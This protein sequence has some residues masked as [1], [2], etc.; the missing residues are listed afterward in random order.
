MPKKYEQEFKD[1]AV[2][3]VR[4]QLPHY[5][6]RTEACIAVGRQEGVARETLRKWL[7]QAEVDSG[8][9]AGCH[10]RTGRRGGPVASGEQEAGRAGSDPLGGGDFLR[11]ST[12]L[13][14][15]M[16]VGF[17]DT[18]RCH[19][20]AV[21]S[22]CAVLTSQG[23]QVAARSYRRWH[24]RTTTAPAA[25]VCQRAWDEAALMNAIHSI[26]YR[27]DEVSGTYRLAPEGLY[28]RR[29]MQ[30]ALARTG[31][32]ASYGRVHSA[33]AALCLNGVRRGKPVRTTIANKD[34]VRA[35]D[36]L[37]RDFTAD[38]PDTTWVADFTYVRTWAGF[39][40][41]A[42]ILDC[43]SQRIVAWHAATS[44]ATALVM[45]PLRMALWDR[46]RNGH[47]V[48][49]GQL[50]SHSDYAEVLVKPRIRELACA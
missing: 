22:V 37:S 5:R 40:Y 19:G 10:E 43:F 31:V 8:G 12:R 41:V 9:A 14:E 25:R 20:H 27:L 24:C 49:A 26:A 18:Q 48:T 21:E 15:A 50:I 16:I 42:F 6:T 2:R 45:T 4:E 38:A 44:K 35:G 36:L 3:L 29:K 1:R 33:M 11:G 32:R 23:C 46:D 30:A 7:A 13:P 17:I 28:G 39:V 34:G 47:P